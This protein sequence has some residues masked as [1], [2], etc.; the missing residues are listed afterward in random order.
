MEIAI[1]SD[2][3]GPEFSRLMISLSGKDGL[4]IGKASESPILYTSMYLVEC[5]Y[6]HKESLAANDI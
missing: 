6:G 4:Q 2:G 1:P 5:L 3:D